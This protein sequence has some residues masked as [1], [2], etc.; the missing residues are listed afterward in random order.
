M[1]ISQIISLDLNLII[2]VLFKIKSMSEF[3]M[4]DPE[5]M[6]VLFN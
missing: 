6:R 3:K 4:F 5:L 2:R 1:K